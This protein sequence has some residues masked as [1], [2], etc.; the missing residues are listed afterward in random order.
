[1]ALSRKPIAR[2]AGSVD[3]KD[4]RRGGTQVAVCP[5]IKQNH[6]YHAKSVKTGPA[7]Q[8]EEP[9]G[10]KQAAGFDQ[11]PASLLAGA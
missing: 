4:P 10:G 5:G 6:Q 3:R 7:H 1:M 2:Q 11:S 8:K 9:F